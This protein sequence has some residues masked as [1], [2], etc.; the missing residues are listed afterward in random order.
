MVD[1]LLARCRL[2]MVAVVA[3]LACGC[4]Q[5]AHFQVWQPA[6]LDVSGIHRLA[7]LDFR[8]Q[9]KTGQ[10]ARSEL[11][12]RLWDSGFYSIVDP[13][14]LNAIVHTSMTG[15]DGEP[16]LREAL[17]VARR[18]GID[19]ILVGEVIRSGSERGLRNGRRI[20]TERGDPRNPYDRSGETEGVEMHR[21]GGPDPFFLER[22]VSVALSVEL[23]DV[24]TGQVRAKRQGSYRADAE[25]HGGQGYV[26]SR[27]AA[28]NEMIA[29]W[30][31]ETTELLTPH[32]IRYEVELAVP[33]L[34]LWASKIREGNND[35][36]KG[37]WEKAARSWQAVL[38]ADPQNH[39][40]LYNLGLAHA[41]RFDYSQAVAMLQDANRLNRNTTYA[42]TL[43]RI[44]R[45]EQAYLMAMSQKREGSLL[46]SRPASAR[47]W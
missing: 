35:A 2:G 44:Q 32:L 43:S 31:R 42:E 11:V 8:G 38:D 36:K 40:A 24:H 5:T 21:R 13:T 34:D 3:A 37:N 30:A 16:D 46:A 39:V 22:D 14:E 1:A 7:V 20:L 33:R 6:E 47:R 41:A 27:E 10:L 4:A 12:A 19:A 45:H 28:T 9:D 23:I 29:K 18:L 15:I 25:L 26:P 17:E